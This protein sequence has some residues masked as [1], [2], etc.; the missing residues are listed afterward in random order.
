MLYSFSFC[1]EGRLDNVIFIQFCTEGRLANVIFIQF[2][3]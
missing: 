2:L 1:T 3:C